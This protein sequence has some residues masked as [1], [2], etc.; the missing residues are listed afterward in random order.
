MGSVA[1]SL[2]CPHGAP[3]PVVVAEESTPWELELYEDE[4]GRAPFAGFLDDL[5]EAEFLA[6]DA[7]LRCVLASQGISLAKTGWLRPLGQG[8]HEFRVRHDAAEIEHMYGS[9]DKP[10]GRGADVLL[11]AFVHF[12]GNR[13]VLLLGGYDKGDDPSPKRQQKE[14]GRARTLLTAWEQGQ[15]KRRS[16]ERKAGGGKGVRS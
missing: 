16:A 12:Y 6:M 14:I 11:R 13:V 10:G 3:Y 2:S 4:R 1:V 7:A 15:A 5:G 9:G 8:L